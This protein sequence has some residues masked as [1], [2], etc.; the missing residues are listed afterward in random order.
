MGVIYFDVYSSNHCYLI[1]NEWFFTDLSISEA[2]HLETIPAL[3]KEYKISLE[4]KFLSFAGSG[5]SNFI[6]FT[7]GGPTFSIDHGGGNVLK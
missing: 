4:A 6:S 7:N 3:G 2:N 1:C 5:E